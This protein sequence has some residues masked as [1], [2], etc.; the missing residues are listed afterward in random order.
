MLRR[1]D[2]RASASGGDTRTT[3]GRSA[4]SSRRLR[5][6]RLRRSTRHYTPIEPHMG[7]TATGGSSRLSAAGVSMIV[8][9]LPFPLALRGGQGVRSSGPE[10]GSGSC[11]AIG[12]RASGTSRSRP[13]SEPGSS[14]HRST[15]TPVR[16]EQPHHDR[17]SQRGPGERLH[18]DVAQ[19]FMLL[20]Q[21][22]RSQNR[23]LTD[24]A[25]AIVAGTDL[26]P[27]R[28]PTPR[29]HHRPTA[30][31]LFAPAN[32]PD[33]DDRSPPGQMNR[34]STTFNARP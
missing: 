13:R 30:P 20:R 34:L 3:R 1:L 23:R 22:A 32:S 10:G 9:G 25:H 4:S 27:R 7:A 17:T 2:P 33:V 18:V 29:P 19:A 26:I 24:L 6:S 28:P 14:R 5:R 15:T 12:T 11:A 16:P 31:A 8:T 21:G